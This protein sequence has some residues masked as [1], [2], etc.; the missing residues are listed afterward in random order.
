MRP[1]DYQNRV[2]PPPDE[3]RDDI[4]NEVVTRLGRVFSIG[5]AC[6]VRKRLVD[7]GLRYNLLVVVEHE[8]Y[9]FFFGGTYFSLKIT[10]TAAN[11]D[12]W[13]RYLSV[14]LK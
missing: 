7:V 8:E 9:A 12:R 1:S 2:G 13:A 11:C 10:G 5:P 14:S 3:N 6:D 4:K